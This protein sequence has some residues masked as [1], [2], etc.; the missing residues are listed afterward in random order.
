MPVLDLIHSF[1]DYDID[2]ARQMSDAIDMIPEASPCLR[3]AVANWLVERP[4]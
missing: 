2:M 3:D 1:F 4:R